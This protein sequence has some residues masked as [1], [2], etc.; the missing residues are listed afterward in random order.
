MAFVLGLV[1]RSRGARP[2]LTRVGVFPSGRT[3]LARVGAP[4]RYLA[5][6]DGVRSRCPVEG[7]S[8]ESEPERGRGAPSSRPH[9]SRS[10]S[11]VEAPRRA[12]LVRGGLD[13]RSRRAAFC[14]GFSH[15]SFLLAMDVRTPILLVLTIRPTS[16]RSSNGCVQNNF[17]AYS[18]FAAN[19]APILCHD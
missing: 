18:T 3:S 16:P 11:A 10:R 8:Y 2:G 15:F 13:T 17:R 14:C 19:R 6:R 7:A 12:G 4:S 1:K 9:T 5:V